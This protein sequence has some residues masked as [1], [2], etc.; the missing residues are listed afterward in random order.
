[1]L[2]IVCV[3]MACAVFV[4]Q[5]QKFSEIRAETQALEQEY[6]ALL[7]EQ[8]RVEYMIEY[9]HSTDYLLQYAREKLGYVRENDIKFNIEGQD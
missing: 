5:E 6:E 8:Q 7:N 1:M 9:A 2:T 4:T 3:V